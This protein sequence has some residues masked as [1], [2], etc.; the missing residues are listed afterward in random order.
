[1]GECGSKTLSEYEGMIETVIYYKNEYHILCNKEDFSLA[2]TNPNFDNIYNKL[3]LRDKPIKII[4]QQSREIEDVVDCTI[5]SKILKFITKR[6][7]GIEYP[8]LKGKFNVLTTYADKRYILDSKH[9]II[10]KYPYHVKYQTSD[11][12][13]FWDII[14]IEPADDMPHQ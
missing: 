6:D 2:P 3:L 1:M 5:Y 10:L 14:S 9:D 12:D 13:G 4:Y 8:Y 11:L 7:I